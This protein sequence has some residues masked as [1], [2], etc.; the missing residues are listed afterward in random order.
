MM[1]LVDKALK[2]SGKSSAPGN[3]SELSKYEDADQIA[4]YAKNGIASLVKEGIAT[5]SGSSMNPRGYAT[6]AEIAVIV[7]RLYNK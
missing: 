5:G 2:I 6:R 3:V 4:S 7:Y 1:T